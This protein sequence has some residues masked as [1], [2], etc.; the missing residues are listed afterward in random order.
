MELQKYCDNRAMSGYGS[1]LLYK[2]ANESLYH[3][4]LPL[5]SA[6]SVSGSVDTFFTS[7][8]TF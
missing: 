4:V 2:E 7:N 3:L 1:A 6:P 5:E 8:L